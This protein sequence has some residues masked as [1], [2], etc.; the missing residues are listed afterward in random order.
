MLYIGTIISSWIAWG[1][2]LAVLRVAQALPRIGFVVA[3]YLANALIFGSVYYLYYRFFPEA[4]PFETMA[5]SMIGLFVVEYIVWTF[6]YDGELWF[7]TWVDW[8][9][10][11]FIVASVIYGVG[12]VMQA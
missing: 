4:K 11:A 12:V 6:V 3:H 2:I 8:I 10:P 9:L 1:V 5:V 7:L